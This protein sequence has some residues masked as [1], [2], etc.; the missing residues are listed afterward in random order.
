MRAPIRTKPR[1]PRTRSLRTVQG[2]TRR[3]AATCRT[4]RNSGR[5]SPSSVDL[6][7]S[8]S[9]V[10]DRRHARFTVPRY[11]IHHQVCQRQRAKRSGIAQQWQPAADLQLVA[12]LSERNDVVRIVRGRFK[13]TK[14]RIPTAQ[15]ERRVV[16]EFGVVQA[17][18]LLVAAA[19]ALAFLAND[20]VHFDARRNCGPRM[21]AYRTYAK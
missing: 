20:N 14:P 12:S 13:V 17:A 3:S 21:F 10:I 15:G 6:S 18:Q 9:C 1:R 4:S 16:V 7:Q 19:N 2:F 11:L 8:K 5:K